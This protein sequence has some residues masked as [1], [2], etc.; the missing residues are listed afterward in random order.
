MLEAFNPES[1]FSNT[2]TCREQCLVTH[3]RSAMANSPCPGLNENLKESCP[4][5]HHLP[6][7]HTGLEVQHGVLQGGWQELSGYVQDE[8]G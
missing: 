1:S 2:P 4:T 7:P 8:E 5:E 3:T 6:E